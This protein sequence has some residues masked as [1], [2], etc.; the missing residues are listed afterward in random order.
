MKRE[1]KGEESHDPAML[2]LRDY[3][4]TQGAIHGHQRDDGYLRGVL[5]PF[6]EEDS[7]GK[8]E[9][10]GE[11]I[12]SERHGVVCR[13]CDPGWLFPVALAIIASGAISQ[14]LW[15]VMR[16]EV[17]GVGSRVKKVLEGDIGLCGQCAYER[18]VK[19]AKG[20]TFILCRRS[21]RD[22]SFPRY[23]RLP[24]MSCPGFEERETDPPESEK[25]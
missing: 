16:Q 22:A 1:P 8:G 18:T 20:S 4:W 9:S 10:S 24:V 7:K 11:E 17:E 3:L 6:S 23:P 2:S 12:T 19:S 14:R 21:E 25:S 5:C 15:C 13:V